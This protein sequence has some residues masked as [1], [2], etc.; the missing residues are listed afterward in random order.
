M[1]DTGAKHINILVENTK[2][3][4]KGTKEQSS[5][6]EQTTDDSKIN[7]YIIYTR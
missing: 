5:K 6:P 3:K 7:S 4:N 2:I 1:T